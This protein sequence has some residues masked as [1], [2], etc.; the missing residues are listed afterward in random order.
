[1]QLAYC[2]AEGPRIPYV[3][4]QYHRSAKASTTRCRRGAWRHFRHQTGPF[5]A[6]WAP[7]SIA[8]GRGPR[9][10]SVRPRDG[11][12]AWQRVGPERAARGCDPG[13]HGAAAWPVVGRPSG[14]GPVE[15]G[16]ALPHGVAGPRRGVRPAGRLAGGDGLVAGPVAAPGGPHP[17][18]AEQHRQEPAIADEAQ[19]EVERDWSVPPPDLLDGGR[20]PEPEPVGDGGEILGRDGPRRAVRGTANQ[21]PLGKNGAGEGRPYPGR[22]RRLRPA[23]VG[24]E[25]CPRGNDRGRTGAAGAPPAAQAT[26][27]RR[28]TGCGARSASVVAPQ[29]GK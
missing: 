8:A 24:R 17:P 23:G 14:G 29:G 21:H 7:R 20:R 26:A 9:T 1:M 28:A 27:S 6:E 2:R 10:T 18:V 11:G 16:V 25:R 5:P 22:E 3:A 13:E 12:H 15:Q 4:K 19:T